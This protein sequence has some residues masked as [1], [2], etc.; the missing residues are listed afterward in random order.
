M[1]K[2]H[3]YVTK[4]EF[5][6]FRQDVEEMAKNVSKFVASM[7]KNMSDLV[8]A[9]SG[10]TPEGYVPMTSHKMIVK[11]LTTIFFVVV[12]AILGISKLIPTLIQ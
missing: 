2:D 7:D 6:E 11:N 8:T 3:Q 4:E 10:K 9:L 12:A 1:S 5:D